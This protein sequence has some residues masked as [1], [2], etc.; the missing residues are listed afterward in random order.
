[1]VNNKLGLRDKNEI[2]PLSVL[3]FGAAPDC[4]TAF[5]L[6]RTGRK[7][8]L[9]PG[10]PRLCGSATYTVGTVPCLGGIPENVSGVNSPKYSFWIVHETNRTSIEQRGRIQVEFSRY[11]FAGWTIA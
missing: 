10:N 6:E 9:E 8:I 7:D 5:R 2:L 11:S 4:A 3:N 1:M